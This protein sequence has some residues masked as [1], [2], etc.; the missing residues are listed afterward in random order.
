ME[1]HLQRDEDN[2][3]RTRTHQ[4]RNYATHPLLHPMLSGPM[5]MLYVDAQV[6]W[7]AKNQ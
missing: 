6:L 1:G 2:D 4:L 5:A 7:H 3:G